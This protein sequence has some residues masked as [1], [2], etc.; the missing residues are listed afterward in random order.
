MAWYIV[1]WRGMECCGVVCYVVAWHNEVPCGVPMKDVSFKARGLYL[2]TSRSVLAGSLS[3]VL[4][5]GLSTSRF[6]LGFRVSLS[7]ILGSD[8][9]RPSNNDFWKRKIIFS[10]RTYP[11]RDYEQA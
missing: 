6:L 7:S 8:S 2:F 5:L 11:S 10:F 4:G 3:S 9:S 1:A